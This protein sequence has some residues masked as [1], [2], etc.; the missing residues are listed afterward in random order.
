MSTGGVF[1][2][3]ANDGK[4]DRIIM[5]TAL[6]DQRINE[7]IRM[8]K[9]LGHIDTLPSLLDIEKTHILFVNSHFKPYA[10][11]GFEYN[12]VMSLGGTARL[13][14]NLTFSLP[15]FG[16]FFNDI[17][18]RIRLNEVS[19][20]S[21]NIP[22]QG[23]KQFPNDIISLDG[24]T[25]TTYLL[26]DVFG[27]TVTGVND[28]ITSWNAIPNTTKTS[29][30]NSNKVSNEVINDMEKNDK[31]TDFQKQKISDFVTPN[32]PVVVGTYRNLVRYC[33]FPG[34]CIFKKVKFNVNGN[35]LTE[36][37]R[38]LSMMMGKFSTNINKQY[39]YNRLLGQQVP[40]QG[41]M[42][43]EKINI[44]PPITVPNGIGRQ[45][46]D[47]ST[48]TTSVYTTPTSL[49]SVSTKFV[50]LGTVGASDVFQREFSI[51]N[52]PQTPKPIQPALELW[53]KL[54]FWFCEDIGLSLPSASIPFG[55]RFIE[56]NLANQDDLVFEYYSLYLKTIVDQI[57]S[58]DGNPD[59]LTHI[60][61]TITYS[62]IQNLFG[63]NPLTINKAE[64][65]INNIFMNPEI[66]DIYLHR[67]TFSLI[68][69]YRE[70]IVSINKTGENSLLLS[71][72]KWPVEVM[73]FG[74]QPHWNSSNSNIYK[75]HDWHRFTLQCPTNTNTNTLCEVPDIKFVVAEVPG[76]ATPSFVTPLVA[77]AP[78]FSSSISPVVDGLFFENVPTI[79]NCSLESHGIVIYDKLPDIFFNQYFPY[80]Y[81][82]YNINTPTD[83]GVLMI[84]MALFPGTY[85]PSG[86]LNLSRV[87]E[88]YIKW[89]S[90]LV[91]PEVPCYAIVVGQCINFILY[92]D[93]SAVLRYST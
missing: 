93:G 19:A 22:V 33:E 29:I 76:G 41:Y 75:Y 39:G 6:L 17:V 30:I 57:S 23:S 89:K 2:L 65:Y 85:Q 81:G 87:R 50:N 70:Q 92:S 56:I 46:E 79:D 13:G 16:D 20:V 4:S 38:N 86:H 43:P 52:G 71:Q 80:Q 42:G 55:Q 51:V 48:Q 45:Y 7:I 36:Y 88:T 32:G 9:K 64:L 14:S 40:T 25:K 8:R 58:N 44:T 74:I 21:G 47:Q 12:K 26:N 63:V 3:I 78:G 84:N 69:V 31:L 60:T 90:S 53:V 37:S 34:N 5:A 49:S 27:N 24:L 15:Q 62:P 82:G 1:K 61:R 67:I 66:H 54:R 73:F 11:I 59:A 10:A 28:I 77:G 83:P 91:S 68:R 18:C 72:L 35:P